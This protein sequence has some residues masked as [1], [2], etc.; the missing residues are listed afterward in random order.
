MAAERAIL[1]DVVAL[2]VDVPEHGV[3]RGNIGT[4]VELLGDDAFEVEFCDDDGHTNAQFAL[5]RDAFLVL[6]GL[7]KVPRPSPAASVDPN[8]SVPASVPDDTMAW[9]AEG[10]DEL[11]QRTPKD[12]GQ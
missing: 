5:A 9:D 12:G 7:S 8:A 11:L 2:L 3:R 10:W 6:R 1:R 4:I